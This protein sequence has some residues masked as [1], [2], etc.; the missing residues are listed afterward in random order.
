MRYVQKVNAGRLGR[1]TDLGTFLFGGERTGLEAYRP[2]LMEVQEGVCLYC[3]K[4]LNGL[5][6]VDH[7]V[8]WSR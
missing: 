2:I 7:I 6:Q 8:P 1:M 3:A 5:V 4:A